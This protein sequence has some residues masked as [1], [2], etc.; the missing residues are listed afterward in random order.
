M[1]PVKDHCDE[2]QTVQLNFLGC[3]I[4]AHWRSFQR[5]WTLWAGCVAP[6]CFGFALLFKKYLDKLSE[7]GDC[8]LLP[9]TSSLFRKWSLLCSSWQT[10]NMMGSNGNVM[11]WSLIVLPVLQILIRWLQSKKNLHLRHSV[12][13]CQIKP[14]SS[15]LF[16]TAKHTCAIAYIWCVCGKVAHR[17]ASRNE[18]GR[19]GT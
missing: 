17:P 14:L 5:D 11:L 9:D 15:S 2:L 18:F 13:C 3:S 10:W 6:S 4:S 1:R 7:A 16:S 8:M 12:D 19:W